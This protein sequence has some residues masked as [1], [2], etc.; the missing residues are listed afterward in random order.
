MEYNNTLGLIFSENVEVSL[1]E[2]M[3]VRSLAAVPV[4][5]RY[6]I[7]DFMLSNMINSGIANVGITSGY[8]NRS[9]VDHVG[10]GRAWDMARKDSGLFILPPPETMDMGGRIIGGI[11]YLSGAM[12]FLYRSRQEYVM[13][14]DCNTI[15]NIDFEKVMDFHFEKEADITVVYT[16]VPNLT[17]K[18]L[19]KHILFDVEED[20]RVKDIQIYP[21]R[22]KS[23]CSYMHMFFMKKS[24]FI[25]MIEDCMAHDEHMISKNILLANVNRRRIFAYKFDG[26]KKKIDNIKTFYQ[27]N[28]ELLDPMVRRE[29]FGNREGNN[30]YTKVKD[31][32]PTKY[33]KDS[34]V[35]N[36]FIADGCQIEGTVENCIVF[37]GVKIGKGTVVK[38]SVIMQKSQ[39]MDNC[40][41]ENVIFD[42]E[43]ILK[44]GK[45][46][47]G[48][49]TYP[50][51]IGKRTV[52]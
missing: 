3:R 6:R 8:K 13:V 5:G 26:Y 20:G 35:K 33:G 22:Q 9:L 43:V 52:V 4:G 16:Q 18:E 2:L 51:V 30:I 40:D 14:T 7:I 11:D 42:K 12:S 48:E 39:I 47:V 23:D 38:N 25:E 29:L 27:F 34:E 31:S 17:E 28:L 1:G 45:S 50:L 49:S 36:S 21:K 37:R 44:G 10:S 32:V 24:L 15:C 19:E 41:V 46:L